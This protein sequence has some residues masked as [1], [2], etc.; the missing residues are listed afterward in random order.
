SSMVRGDLDWIV[1]KALEKDRTRRYETATSLA[2]DIQRHLN[3]ELIVAR[4]PGSFYRLQKLARRNKLAFAAATAV[5]ASLAL[6][7]GFSTWMLV[8]ERQ[9]R[10]EADAARAREAVLRQKAEA[11]EKIPEARLLLEANNY[12]EAGKLLNQIP[13][14]L[15][16]PNPVHADLRRVLGWWHALH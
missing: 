13:A 11:R 6:G 1:M 5:F 2:M 16:E 12:D 9:A 10:R 3:N 15:L 7:L 8:G 4:P 14:A